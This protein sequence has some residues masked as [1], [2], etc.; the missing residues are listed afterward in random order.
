MSPAHDNRLLQALQ[1]NTKT[2]VEPLPDFLNVL[3]VDD[4]GSMDAEKPSVWQ[5]RL[6]IFHDPTNQL[7]T[8]TQGS[9]R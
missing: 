1:K 8:E 2:I 7:G 9:G 3:G 6:P 4:R 5:S